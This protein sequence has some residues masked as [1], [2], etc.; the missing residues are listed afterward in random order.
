[1][2]EMSDD[3]VVKAAKMFNWGRGIAQAEVVRRR[4]K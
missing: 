3:V 4:L 1:M 2:A